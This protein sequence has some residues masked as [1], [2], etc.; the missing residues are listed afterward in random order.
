MVNYLEHN[1]ILNKSQHGFRKGRSCLT[2]L[3]S[4][5]DNILQNLNKN[6]ETDVIYLDYAKAFDKVDHRILLQKLHAYGI[7]GK[8]YNWIKDF[9]SNRLQ[10]VVINGKH[11]LRLIR[12]HFA[13]PLLRTV[14]V[15]Y[16]IYVVL[17]PTA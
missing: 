10:T 5:Y 16:I 2:Q 14:G 17:R 1:N 8:L 4:H 9:L 13:I 12:F 6:C 11:S 15:R 3:L 7:R